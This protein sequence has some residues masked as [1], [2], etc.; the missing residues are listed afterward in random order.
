[1]LILCADAGADDEIGGDPSI[2]T[3]PD[4]IE[5][6]PR[7]VCVYLVYH[8]PR[9]SR[10][11]SSLASLEFLSPAHDYLVLSDTLSFAFPHAPRAPHSPIALASLSFL[12]LA[13]LSL[14]LSQTWPI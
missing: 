2:D 8:A 13:R 1:M 5:Y 9:P 3:S 10:W 12:L 14:V 7:K 11:L 6:H 4:Q